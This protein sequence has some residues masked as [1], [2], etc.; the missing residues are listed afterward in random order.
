[1]TSIRPRRSPRRGLCFA[2]PA[3][4]SSRW[5]IFAFRNAQSGP[6]PF[7]AR[8]DSPR[9]HR[10]AQ[11]LLLVAHGPRSVLVLFHWSH[12]CCSGRSALVWGRFDVAIF[13]HAEG[14]GPECDRPPLPRLDIAASAYRQYA[15]GGY[16]WVKPSRHNQLLNVMT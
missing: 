3:R 15:D 12:Y 4:K 11:T 10:E 14:H 1:M 6:V 13:D 2:A 8:K 5:D 16:D 9:G 7:V